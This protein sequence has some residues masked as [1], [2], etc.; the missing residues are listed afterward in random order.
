MIIGIVAHD[1]DKGIGIN[2]KIPWH[3][4]FDFQHFKRT[5]LN[6]KVLMG[7]KTWESL[8][9]KPL[10]NRENI[11]LTRDKNLTLIGQPIDN[12]KIVNE[13]FI[14]KEDLYVIGGSEIYK[15]YSLY[16][17]KLIVTKILGKYECDTF[18]ELDYSKWNETPLFENN[19]L[20]IFEYNRPFNR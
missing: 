10:P 20:K 3:F 14:P 16:F 6:K 8:P 11:I 2:N 9:K 19:D 17:D 4:S 5:T 1:L 18:F 12:V 15:L 7:R 13:L